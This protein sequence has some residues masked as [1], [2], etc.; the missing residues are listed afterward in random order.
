MI[1][2]VIKVQPENLNDEHTPI[3]VPVYEHEKFESRL[4]RDHSSQ[5]H[6]PVSYVV[7]DH[8]ISTKE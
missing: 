2:V 5:D 3:F 4:A 1:K 6:L 8:K 7:I